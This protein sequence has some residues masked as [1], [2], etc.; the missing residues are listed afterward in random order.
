[1]Q[2]QII[3]HIWHSW[4]YYERNPSANFF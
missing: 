3:F 4:L 1:M 2:N